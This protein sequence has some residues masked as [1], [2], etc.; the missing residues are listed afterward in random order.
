MWR[1]FGAPPLCP[2]PAHVKRAD[3]AVPRLSSLRMLAKHF[4]WRKYSCAIFMCLE[5]WS[6]GVSVI[7]SCLMTVPFRS[8]ARPRACPSCSC[9]Q[10]CT[11]TPYAVGGGGRVR[12]GWVKTKERVATS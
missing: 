7:G 8:V 9:R 10:K 2:R 4:C 1:R 5:G 6:R 3:G 12:E 11:S